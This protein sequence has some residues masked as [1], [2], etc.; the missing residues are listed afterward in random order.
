MDEHDMALTRTHAARAEVEEAHHPQQ[1][2]LR[3]DVR[4]VLGGEQDVLVE[5]PFPAYAPVGAGK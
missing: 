3:W 5:D 2:R 1:P 4:L